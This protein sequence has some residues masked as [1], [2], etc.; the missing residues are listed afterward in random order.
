M[1]DKTAPTNVASI[2]YAKAAQ[3]AFEVTQKLTAA[4]ATPALDYQYR[5]QPEPAGTLRKSKSRARKKK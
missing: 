1:D 5:P 2:V 3:A 4:N